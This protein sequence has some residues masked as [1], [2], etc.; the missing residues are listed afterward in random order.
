MI[1]RIKGKV[2]A[3]ETPIGLMPNIADLDLT[4][5]DIN[6]ETMEKLFE[7]DREEWT[8]EAEEI[9]QFYAQFGN[10]LPEALKQHLEKLK[11]EL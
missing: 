2:S 9:E 8:K 4:G 1:D 3:K 10:R 11:K 7:V 6:K 5:L